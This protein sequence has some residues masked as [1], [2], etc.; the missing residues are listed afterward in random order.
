MSRARDLADTGSKANFLDNV[1]A[2]IPADIDATYAPKESPTFTGTTNVSSGVTLP[3]NPTIVLGSN[4][5]FPDGHVIQFNYT[6]VW[7]QSGDKTY[8]STVNA[9]TTG[10]NVTLPNNLTSGSTVL[11]GY[12]HSSGNGSLSRSNDIR[13]RAQKRSASGSWGTIADNVIWPDDSSFSMVF[14][15]PTSSM[16]TTELW[17]FGIGVQKY[18]STASI[19]IA[20]N[21][22]QW[23]MFA[24]EIK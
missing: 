3:S 5:T 2:N 15:V 24:M 8:T 13:I 10:I 23:I 22:A 12:I 4:A 9:G 18:S 1:T 21:Y 11:A 20:K 7:F 6:N 16:N 14:P 19:T 17:S